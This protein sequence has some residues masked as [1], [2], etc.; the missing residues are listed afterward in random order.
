[1]SRRSQL[2]KSRKYL[3]AHRRE[4]I[5]AYWN[6]HKKQLGTVVDGK[7]CHLYAPAHVQRVMRGE[8][9]VRPV[10]ICNGTGKIVQ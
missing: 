7:Y 3:M 9:P 2:R 5:A 8:D 1:M 10:L 6:T 4:I